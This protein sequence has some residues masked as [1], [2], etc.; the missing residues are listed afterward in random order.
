MELNTEPVEAV[1]SLMRTYSRVKYELTGS[2]AYA[3][4]F[5][6]PARSR[7]YG[8]FKKLYI[9]LMQRTIDPLDYLRWA[10]T[11][12]KTT[13]NAPNHLVGEWKFEAYLKA[14]RKSKAGAVRDAVEYETML[15]RAKADMQVAIDRWQERRRSYKD[16]QE[17]LRAEYPALPALFLA[18]DTEFFE[19][20]KSSTGL[21]VDKL[22]AVMRWTNYLWKHK[23]LAKEIRT[24]RDDALRLAAAS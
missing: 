2:K 8:V 20:C 22:N 6:N 11:T 17:Y 21:M 13:H 15:G 10:M 3:K 14:R 1:A 5:W 18:T 12:D 19:I 16:Y 4:A 23:A 9:E 24:L 7:W